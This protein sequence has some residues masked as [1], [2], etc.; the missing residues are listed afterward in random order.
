MEKPSLD[1]IGFSKPDV[2]PVER[3]PLQVRRQQNVSIDQQK[4]MDTRAKKHLG[5][6]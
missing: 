6:L 1:R 4:L 5:D 3:V 2:P